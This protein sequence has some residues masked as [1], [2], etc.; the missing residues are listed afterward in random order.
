MLRSEEPAPTSRLQSTPLG[1]EEQKKLA[2]TLLEKL[3]ATATKG[4]KPA[5]GRGGLL[6]ARADC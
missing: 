5:G 4:D 1:Y 2:R 6:E 3:W